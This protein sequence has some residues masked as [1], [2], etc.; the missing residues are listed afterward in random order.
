MIPIADVIDW[1][2]LG[3][4]NYSDLTVPTNEVRVNKAHISFKQPLECLFRPYSSGDRTH[5]LL[6]SRCILMHILSIIHESIKFLKAINP[7]Q[8]FLLLGF[9]VKNRVLWVPF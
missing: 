8:F 2:I 4:G 9:A 5:P 1:L 3:I 7:L 6:V